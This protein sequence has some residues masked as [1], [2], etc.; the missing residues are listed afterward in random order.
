VSRTEKPYQFIHARHGLEG[1][2]VARSRSRTWPHLA[3][4]ES[5]LTAQHRPPRGTFEEGPIERYPPSQ[6]GVPPS[7]NFPLYKRR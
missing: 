7:L 3:D 6:P 1:P 5:S 4:S 2:A